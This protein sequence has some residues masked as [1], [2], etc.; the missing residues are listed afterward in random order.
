M[1]TTQNATSTAP[2]TQATAEQIRRVQLLQELAQVQKEVADAQAEHTY[3]SQRVI[4]LE[5]ALRA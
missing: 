3:L 4:A 2:V 1:K 5:K